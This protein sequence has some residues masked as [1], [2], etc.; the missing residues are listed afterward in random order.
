MSRIGI[1]M[2]FAVLAGIAAAQEEP[3]LKDE[4][5]KNSYAVGVDTGYRLKGMQ[6][7]LDAE[8]VAR[9]VK[10]ALSGD[11]TLL[12]DEELKAVLAA[13][14]IQLRTRQEQALKQLA[15][16]NKKEG[17][18]FLTENK[19]REGVITLESGLQYRVLEAGNGRKPTADDTVVCHYRGT[20]IDGKEFDSSLS[21][22][23]P[24]EFAL[25]RVIKGWSEALQIMPVGSKWQLFIPPE[26]AYGELGTRGAIGPNATLVF[27]VALLS[28]K[29]KAQASREQPESAALQNV[30][31]GPT[32]RTVNP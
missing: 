6:V 23:Q 19:T 26:L 28:I 10:D 31:R 25:K 22:K 11:E 12:T 20:L 13:L 30:A 29:D 32:G 5:A 3:A 9:G 2:V 21:R 7:D 15:E 8:L 24:A 18:A 14:R 27:E 16:K 1:S 4:K 17:E